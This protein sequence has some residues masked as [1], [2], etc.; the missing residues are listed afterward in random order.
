MYLPAAAATLNLR[1]CI[2][3]LSAT[4]D[5][6]DQRLLGRSATVCGRCGRTNVHGVGARGRPQLV[7][8]RRTGRSEAVELHLQLDDHRRR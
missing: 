5:A 8:R 1:V 3:L 6:D 2:L 7:P 4:G